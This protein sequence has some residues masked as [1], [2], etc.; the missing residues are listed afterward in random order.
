MGS[1]ARLQQADAGARAI[2]ADLAD[3]DRAVL[4]P[5]VDAGLQRNWAEVARL[6]KERAG[7]EP[8][9]HAGPRTSYDDCL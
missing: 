1:W 7:P 4:G 9:A 5:L 6:A 3:A 2:V 8:R